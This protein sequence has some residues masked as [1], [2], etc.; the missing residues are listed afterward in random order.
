MKKNKRTI[1]ASEINRF[2]YCNYQWYYGK[3]YGSTRLRELVNERNKK[4]KSKDEALSNFKKG[5][6]YHSNYHNKYILKQR[7]YKIIMALIFI[8][9]LVWVITFRNELGF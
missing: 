1:S 9:I 6:D 2:V 4:L 7:I 8:F 3:I 5:L